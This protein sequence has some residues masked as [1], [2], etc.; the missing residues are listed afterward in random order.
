MARA[1]GL[2]G[3]WVA[4]VTSDN[5]RLWMLMGC[6]AQIIVNRGRDE[7][8]KAARAY[9]NGLLRLLS[10]H[11][12]ESVPPSCRPV[13]WPMVLLHEG[14]GVADQT[15]KRPSNVP[16]WHPGLTIVRSCI[17]PC[18]NYGRTSN[19]VAVG[20]IYA[21]E[22]RHVSGI[23]AVHG[24]VTNL[25]L[26]I[27]PLLERQASRRHLIFGPTIGAFEDDRHLPITC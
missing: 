23:P 14:L 17:N 16:R 13:E 24:L 27:A 10:C 2:R 1:S 20:C 9:V 5:R 19:Y 11:L 21:E 22:N 8:R 12:V 4:F 3:R 25:A 26:G 6:A 7:M 15:R 18:S